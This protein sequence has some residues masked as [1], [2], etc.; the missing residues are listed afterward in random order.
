VSQRDVD[1]PHLCELSVPRWSCGV[2]LLDASIRH[3]LM[4]LRQHSEQYV[5]E[6][7][8]EPTAWRRRFDELKQDL[9]WLEFVRDY[10]LPPLPP[11]PPPIRR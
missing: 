2:N 11:A 1:F 10:P 7:V 8:V 5:A 4:L 6:I 3:V 9:H